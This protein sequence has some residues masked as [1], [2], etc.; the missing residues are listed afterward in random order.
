MG[1]VI[2]LR[3]INCVLW[4]TL[5]SERS[6]T[7]GNPYHL[8]SIMFTLH[9]TSFF[10]ILRTS[11]IKGGQPEIGTLSQKKSSTTERNFRNCLSVDVGRK[12]PSGSFYVNSFTGLLVTTEF[13]GSFVERVPK[14]SFNDMVFSVGLNKKFPRNKSW[15][16][17]IENPN[18][19]PWKIFYSS[20]NDKLIPK[21]SPEP[22][23]NWP[24]KQLVLNCKLSWSIHFSHAWLRELFVSKK[25]L[26][27]INSSG[28]FFFSSNL[29]KLINWGPIRSG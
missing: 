26:F 29:F 19:P 6:K 7:F 4:H 2:M 1:F 15:F 24:L 8:S 11:L 17:T 22:M 13:V 5:D 20:D 9:K 25:V 27:L 12:K 3:Q 10:W 21:S 18:S 14:M 16:D 28:S 23:I